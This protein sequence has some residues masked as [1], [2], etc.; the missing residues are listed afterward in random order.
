MLR[1]V[2][3]QGTA[4][5]RRLRGG[6]DIRGQSGITC[7]PPGTGFHTISVGPGT[8]ARF[9]NQ[10]NTQETLFL[11]AAPFKRLVAM[12]AERAY[13]EVSDFRNADGRQGHHTSTRFA[14][15]DDAG[16]SSVVLR[17]RSVGDRSHT[18]PVRARFFSSSR[19]QFDPRVVK[20]GAVFEA[21]WLSR[22]LASCCRPRWR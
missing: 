21:G 5:N 16:S 6:S 20:G 2:F 4:E 15:F 14:H 10:A 12:A 8:L 9:E 1:G 18:S 7:P 19:S 11:A 22:P 13:T 17:Q 3:G